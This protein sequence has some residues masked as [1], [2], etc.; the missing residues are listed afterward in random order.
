MNSDV[1]DKV[2]TTSETPTVTT[3]TVLFHPDRIKQPKRSIWD[4]I[5]YFIKNYFKHH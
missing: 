2:T 1:T 3:T 4:K 5:I